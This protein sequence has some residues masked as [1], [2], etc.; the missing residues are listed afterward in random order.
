MAETSNAIFLRTTG[1]AQFRFDR[2]TTTMTVDVLRRG[3]SASAGRR[4]SCLD[5]LLAP[6]VPEHRCCFDPL[7]AETKRDALQNRN[8]VTVLGAFSSPRPP[9]SP[10][11]DSPPES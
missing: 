3:V 4:G 10:A 9:Q 7:R 5:P 8:T 1:A 2:R 11:A 6:H